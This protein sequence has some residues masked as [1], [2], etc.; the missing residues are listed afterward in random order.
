MNKKTKAVRVSGI[1]TH[2]LVF[3]GLADFQ[4][5]YPPPI[6]TTNYAGIQSDLP[7][8]STIERDPFVRVVPI[9]HSHRNVPFEYFFHS[10]S[11][12]CWELGTDLLDLEV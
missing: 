12:V 3:P 10:D 2:E 1:V 11:G 4:L 6:H 8:W 7:D 9:F 5:H